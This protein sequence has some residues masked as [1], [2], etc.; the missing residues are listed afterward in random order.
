VS[1]EPHLWEIKHPYYGADGHVNEEESF[2][3]LK[4][5]V[6]GSDED[7]NLI[8]RWDWDDPAT[9]EYAEP[10]ESETFTVYLLMPRKSGFWSVSCP[11][12]KHQEFEVLEWLQGPRC[13]GHLRKLWE[14]VMET[15]P[16]GDPTEREAAIWGHHVTA[17][18]QIQQSVTGQLEA[19]RER[20]ATE[21]ES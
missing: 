12:Q 2:A 3:A 8:Y 10:D 4:A 17:L 19:A 9:N 13:F 15:L 1:N 7:M 5:N 18:E 16:A 6:D 20:A 11:I 14:P 21:E